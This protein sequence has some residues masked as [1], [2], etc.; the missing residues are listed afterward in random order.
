M[1]IVESIRTALEGIW[2]NKMRSAL[3]MLGIIIGVAAVIAV[4]AIGEGGRAS[5]MTSLEGMGTNLFV[6]YPSSRNSETPLTRR[7]MV[8]LE[9]IEGVRSIIPTLKAVAPT[10]WQT[11]MTQYGKEKQR[12]N[13][14]STTGDYAA[15]RNLNLLEGRFLTDDED[16][17]KRRVIVINEELAKA[18]F[19][20]KSSLGKQIYLM[21]TPFTVIGVIKN[22]PAAP[23]GMS[24]E[25]PKEAA[26]P[27]GTA[28]TIFGFLRIQ[29]EG[30]TYNKEEVQETIDQVVKLLHKRHQNEDKYRGWSLDQEAATA[31]QILGVVALVV[32]SIAG[33]SLL[34][35]GIG[36]M[37]IMLVSVT[38]RT[39]EIG[40]RMALGATRKDILI[41]FLIEAVV[42]CVI[43]GIIGTIIGVGGAFIVAMIAQWPPLVSVRTI[44]VAF[45][46][47][48]TIGIFFG[49]YPANKAS[50]LDPIDALRY[51]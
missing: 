5:V 47:S 20:G 15:I 29:I 3:T 4:I 38:E 7:D 45:A 36:V 1:E 42:I 34:V 37:N 18:F 16:K 6:V 40:I 44:L 2:A 22:D 43:G 35:G 14:I 51:E 12:T 17:S 8:T 33:I 27:L 30:Q 49:I 9:D 39:R 26:I 31:N 19:P 41:Q 21:S 48:A 28:Q 10:A 25:P 24:G 46:F 32:G 13:I 23:F 11:T 50:K